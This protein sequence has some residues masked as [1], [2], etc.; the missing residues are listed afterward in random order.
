MDFGQRHEFPSTKHYAVTYQMIATT[1]YREYYDPK[2]VANSDN[3]T[4]RSEK[5]GSI[6]ILNTVPPPAPDLAYVLPILIWEDPVVGSQ[7]AIKK[8]APIKRKVRRGLRVYMRRNWYAS[9]EEERLGVV[10]A[11]KS[12]IEAMALDA[13]PDNQVPVT[14]WGTNPIWYTT[15]VKRQP[16]VDDALVATDM[17]F[18]GI[19]VA[20][21]SLTAAF[22]AQ[23]DT[24]APVTSTGTQPTPVDTFRKPDEQVMLGPDEIV[25]VDVAAF[26]VECDIDKDLI[27][28]DIEFKE[29]GS[30][31]PMVKMALARFQPYSAPYA[32]LSPVTNW[33]FHAVAPERTIAYGLVLETNEDPLHPTRQLRFSLSGLVP[34]NVRE[35][36]RKNSLEVSLFDG[37]TSISEAQIPLKVDDSARGF[38]IPLQILDR[39]KHPN[40]HIKEFEYVGNSDPRLV[41]AC[42]IPLDR[43]L[44]S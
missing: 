17:R 33:V 2:F 20:K 10:F 6:H 21:K 16:T 5:S 14:Q 24:V 38:L 27:Y 19:A 26:A 7:D 44:L 8:G 32:Y 12:K 29:T 43:K 18:K 1:R 35:G 34:G 9:G 39:L 42:Q 31:S 25:T 28:A 40:V 13:D 37:E 4:I 3:I 11:P 22:A 41:L 30:Y 36:Y 15:P 23:R